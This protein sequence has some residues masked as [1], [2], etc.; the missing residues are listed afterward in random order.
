MPRR[1]ELPPAT[2]AQAKLVLPVNASITPWCELLKSKMFYWQ[3][4]LMKI[5]LKQAS[6]PFSL[7]LALC[8]T[9]GLGGCASTSA[10][11]PPPLAYSRTI[12][13]PPGADVLTANTYAGDA[14]ANILLKRMG[15][16]NSILATAM[17]EMDNLGKS[18][19]FGRI[20]MQQ[21]ASRVS[22]HGFKVLDVRMTE[23]MSISRD[24]EFM[25]SRD[26]ANLL[27][28]EHN[29]H[30]VL[31]GVYTPAGNKIYVSV[32]ALRLTD[33]AVLAAYEY[34]LPMQGDTQQLLAGGG[35]SGG[36]GSGN[37]TWSRYAARGQAFENCNQPRAVASAEPR[38]VAPAQSSYK[39]PVQSSYKP[40]VQKAGK[41]SAKKK[42]T[43]K[44][45]AKCDPAP[46]PAPAPVNTNILCPDGSLPICPDNRTGGTSSR[47]TP[48]GEAFEDKGGG[49]WVDPNT[50]PPQAGK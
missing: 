36:S 20:S 42:S 19:A 38:S 7:L 35:G 43:K 45:A 11:G 6:V 3:V 12:D 27:A 50:A 9:L 25:L 41:S 13:P 14:I 5:L 4:T 24:G 21:I 33:N 47:M 22:Q 16:G 8:L 1:Q 48:Y 26:T 2:K 28:R 40:S 29:A 10:D 17:V 31:V 30:A 46:A 23:A 32:R 18:S 44:S 49:K 15:S 37:A 34:Y 39:P